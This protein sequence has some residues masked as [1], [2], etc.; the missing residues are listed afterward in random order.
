MERGGSAFV[1]TCVCEL[2]KDLSQLCVVRRERT[3]NGYLVLGSNCFTQPYGKGGSLSLG[4]VQE[5]MVVH[6]KSS[7]PE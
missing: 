7:F 5:D 2:D 3:Q 6:S 1:S 4:F